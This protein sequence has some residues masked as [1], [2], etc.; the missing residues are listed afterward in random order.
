MKDKVDEE[1][2]KAGGKV[3]LSEKDMEDI[4]REVGT[5]YVSMF[6]EIHN[7]M[8]DTIRKE[9]T[10]DLEA[11]RLYPSMIP[12]FKKQ[13]VEGYY[14]S[15]V[16]PGECVGI[17]CAQ[18]IGERQTQ[19]TLNS[20]HSAGLLTQTVVTGVP[21][22]LEL[23]NATK[24]PKL[25]SCSFSLH[26]EIN[27]ELTSPNDIRR[28]IEYR[29]ASRSVGQLVD[30]Y[31]IFYDGEEELWYHPF[32]VQYSGEFR[33]Y[34]V[35]IK[36]FL[37]KAEVWEHR[38][39]LF[40]IKEKIEE[41]YH[42]CYV[43]FSPQHLC[44]L[45]VFVDTSDLTFPKHMEESKYLEIYLEEVVIPKLGEVIVCGCKNIQR[46][47]IQKE[48]DKLFR[49]NTLGSNL[50]ELLGHP[51]VDTSSVYCNNMWEVLECLG[52]EATREFL[53][54][55]FHRVVSSDGT[56]IHPSHVR[57][58]VDFMTYHGT[59]TSISRYGMKKETNGPLSKASFEEVMDHFLTASFM[60]ETEPVESISA[61]IICG[62]RSKTGTGLCSLVMDVSAISKREKE[63]SS[64]PLSLSS[65][66]SSSP[67][68]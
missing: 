23:L 6:P 61:S 67:L 32:E 63:L 38:I 34:D 35:G 55:E 21:R 2:E 36:L 43:V 62:K 1:K 26:P 40:L 3:S 59:I 65:L 29:L 54:E 30:K 60:A 47:Y 64:L 16:E 19:L 53:L 28:F 18:S 48:S 5:L 68:S 57:L 27:K 7:N 42:D 56:F 50:M 4:F 37:K 11:V 15:L 14:M 41:A 58:L 13:V 24:D 20:F 8:M 39:P 51:D 22:F 10:P 52:I 17:T 9:W 46:V 66:L 49:L 45:D 12:T 44:Q 25:T 31:V 33:N